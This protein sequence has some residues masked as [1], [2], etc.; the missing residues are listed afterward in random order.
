MA[1]APAADDA[2]LDEYEPTRWLITEL[3]EPE[4]SAT[5]NL[6]PPAILPRSLTSDLLNPKP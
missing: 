1:T 3:M 2:E 4:V 6:K 5:P